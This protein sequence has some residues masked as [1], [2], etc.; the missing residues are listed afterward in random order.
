MGASADIYSNNY[1][2]RNNDVAHNDS[3]LADNN[4]TVSVVD[5]PQAQ[6]DTPSQYHMRLVKQQ[7]PLIKN[8]SCDITPFTT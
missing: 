4:T 7:I 8:I 3:M 1:S 5:R 2:G 6:V